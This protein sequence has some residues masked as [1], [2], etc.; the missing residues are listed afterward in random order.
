MKKTTKIAALVL[1]VATIATSMMACAGKTS[2][3]DQIKKNGYVTM[4]TEAT[5][6]PFEYMDGGKFAGIDVEISQKVADKLGVKLKINNVK[7]DSLINE[8]QSNKANFVAAGMT[9][10]EDRKKNVD[11]SNTYFK[12]AQSIIVKKGS[13]NIAKPADL[14]GKVVGVQQGT[15]GDTYCTDEDK[16]NNVNVK[17][18]KRFDTAVD[19]VSDLMKGNVDAVVIDNFPAEKLVSKNS[20]KITKLSDALTVEEYAIA[21]KKGD[22][23][24]LKAVN[25]VLSQMQSDGSL[26]KLIEKYKSALEGK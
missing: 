2:T 1:A 11:F 6:E 20:D 19:A 24:M 21:V 18:V 22:T 17:T 26:D 23:E 3:V 13:T 16:K 7:F 15:T 8:L 12:A 25:D 9:A 14:A 4:S 10:T 5:F